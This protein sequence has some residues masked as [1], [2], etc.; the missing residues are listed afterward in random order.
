MRSDQNTH[1]YPIDMLTEL[2]LLDVSKVI[3]DLE[4]AVEIHQ[5]HLSI[6]PKDQDIKDRLKNVKLLLCFLHFRKQ[7]L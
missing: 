5:I 6:N 7:G 2:N 1:V 4:Q 3:P